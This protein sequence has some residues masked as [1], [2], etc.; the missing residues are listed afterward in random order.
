MSAQVLL[1]LLK[2]FGKVIKSEACRAF[3]RFH[4][5]SLIISIIQ[6]HKC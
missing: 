3:Y 2:E 4:T 5:T 6:E 1:S